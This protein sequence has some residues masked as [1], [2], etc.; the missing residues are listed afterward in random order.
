MDI[1]NME[2]NKEAPRIEVT[3]FSLIFC[4][5]SVYLTNNVLSF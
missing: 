5:D 3:F 4:N 1:S 2:K